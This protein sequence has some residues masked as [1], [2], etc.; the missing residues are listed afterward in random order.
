MGLFTGVNRLMLQIRRPI[1]ERS[2][3]DLAYKRLLFRM[4]SHVHLSSTFM[5]K[6]FRAHGMSA[7]ERPLL[8]VDGAD[9]VPLGAALAEAAAA[10][11]ALVR[12]FA[13][14][15]PLMRV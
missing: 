13:R 14:M 8:H 4:R 11:L 10:I 7:R 1:A 6:G 2:L 12:F 9:V 5:R 3:A 15:S